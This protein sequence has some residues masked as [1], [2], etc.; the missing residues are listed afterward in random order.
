MPADGQ[1]GRTRN[2]NSDDEG[3]QAT[4]PARPAK[5]KL[6]SIGHIFRRGAAGGRLRPAAAHVSR[7]PF[8]P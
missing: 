1:R 7:R 6:A 8:G 5:V 4:G 3:R 2:A